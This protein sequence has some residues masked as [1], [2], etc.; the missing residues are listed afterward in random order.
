MP[1][2]KAYYPAPGKLYKRWCDYCGQPFET[3]FKTVNWCG[4]C[5]KRTGK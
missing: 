1:N 5:D 2:Y 4:F 3:E